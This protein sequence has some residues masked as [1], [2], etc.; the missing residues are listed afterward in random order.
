MSVS[1]D[2]SSVG[3]N[4]SSSHM[5]EFCCW[6]FLSIVVGGRRIW[7]GRCEL[8]IGVGVRR[9]GVQMIRMRP[10]HRAGGVVPKANE[11][12]KNIVPRYLPRR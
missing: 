11:F 5:G 9:S 3:N 2:C 8:R 1:L 12:Q 7:F 4:Q 6:P 10:N